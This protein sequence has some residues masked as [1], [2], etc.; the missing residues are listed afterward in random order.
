MAD[1]RIIVA[2]TGASGAAYCQRL[3]EVLSA[4]G[5]IEV[6]LLASKTGLRV[7]AHELRLA[8]PDVR[9][10]A[11]AFAAEGAADRVRPHGDDFFAPV[12]S[13]SFRFE[14]MVVVPCSGGRLG[15]LAAGI[16]RDLIDRAVEV[17]L[18][19]GR[20]LIVV[21]RE[22]PLSTI[23]LQNMTRLAEAG[24]VVLPASPGFYSRP[25]SVSDTVDFVVA[26]ILDQLGVENDLSK[27]WGERDGV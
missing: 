4:E 8:L 3:V 27:R 9:A 10:A 12:A 23:H 6:H 25:E 18:K 14:S 22:T 13:G 20:R 15:S 19:E 11:A 24:A 21:P 26:R 7:A 17:T 5:G 2:L 1:R 16:C